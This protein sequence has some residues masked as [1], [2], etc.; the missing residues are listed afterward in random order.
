MKTVDGETDRP[1]LI[2]WLGSTIG[3]LAPDEAADFL[4][5]V[6]R[7]MSAQDR[8][9]VGIDLRKG[10]EVLEGAYDDSAGV[11][12][13]FNINLLERIPNHHLVVFGTEPYEGGKLVIS[14][15]P[16]W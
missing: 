9:L 3:N 12:A 16:T 7:A 13:R 4:D 10:R 14:L 5:R 15:E 8:L 2:A 1:K 11:T 6:R